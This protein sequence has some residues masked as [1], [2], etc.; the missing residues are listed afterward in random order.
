LL[1][2]GWRRLAADVRPCVWRDTDPGL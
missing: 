2:R 1:A